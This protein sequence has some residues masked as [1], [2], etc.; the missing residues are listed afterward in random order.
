MSIINQQSVCKIKKSIS[1]DHFI[2]IIHIPGIFYI[3]LEGIISIIGMYSNKL[4]YVGGN[5][6]QTVHSTL[7][8]ISDHHGYVLK[9]EVS[10]L[11]SIHLLTVRFKA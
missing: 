8:P 2:N 3:L 4:Q 7:K 11:L 1:Y 9:T 10:R 5:F 6:S